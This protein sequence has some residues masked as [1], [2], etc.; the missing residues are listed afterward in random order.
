[1]ATRDNS[2]QTPFRALTKAWLHTATL[3]AVVSM[4]FA[5]PRRAAEEGPATIYFFS[6]ET[7]INNFNMLKGEFDSFFS[8]AGQHKFQPFRNRSDFENVLHNQR[9]GLFLMSSWHYAQMPDKTRWRPYLVGRRGNS[10]T[11]RHVVSARAGVTNLGQ[12]RGKTIAAA[13]SKEFA[14]ELLLQMLPVGERAQISQ[15]KILTVPKDIDALMSVGFGIAAAAITTEHGLDRLAKLNPRQREK[16]T[17]VATGP[18]KLLPVITGPADAG[19]SGAALRRVLLEMGT[20][21]E[22]Q[23]LLSMLGLDAW[24]A[25]EPAHME[26]LLK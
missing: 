21:P 22:G 19:A 14:T 4:L 17:L 8:S 12:L 2:I 23:Q 11:Q 13:G 3:A 24:G 26:V 9:D 18:E 7:S 25:I 5:L 15:Y 6:S 10:S 20:V 16:L 1:M